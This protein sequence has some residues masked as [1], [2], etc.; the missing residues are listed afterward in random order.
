MYYSIKLK[1]VQHFFECISG[2]SGLRG[3][4]LCEKAFMPLRLEIFSRFSFLSVSAEKPWTNKKVLL[5]RLSEP[6]IC[7]NGVKPKELL[8]QK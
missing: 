2:N 4:I 8:W 6:P 7:Y 1:F 3:N 5:G